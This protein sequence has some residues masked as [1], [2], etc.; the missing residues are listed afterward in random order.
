MKRFL[1]FCIVV[2]FA[3]CKEELPVQRPNVILIMADDLGWGDTGFNG[4]SV[5]QTPNLDK[6]AG[7]GMVFNRFYSASA[8]CSPTRASC[9]IGRNPYRTNVITANSGY[10][11]KEEVT[12]AEVLKSHGYHTGHFGKWHLG[13]LTTKIKDA[14]RGRPGNAEEFSIPTQHG[15]EV[16]F[17]TESKVPT[18]DPMVK[19]KVFQTEKG[20]GLR[21]G[22]EAIDDGDS[23]EAY[24]THYWNG[25]EMMVQEDLTGDDSKIIIDKA[26]D[27][28]KESSATEDP[29]FSVIWLH[30]PH[31]PVVADEK[32]RNMYKT[33]DLQEQLYY[34]TITALDEQIGRLWET[35]GELG[36]QQNTMIWFCSDNGPERG[37]PG[38]SGIYR[39]RKR[40][41]YE[42][43]VRVPAFCVWENGVQPSQI[44][45]VPAVTS[46]YFPTILDM[47][48][49]DHQLNRPMDGVSLKMVMSSEQSERGA[50]IGFLFNN[51]MSWVSDQYK[52]ISTDEGNTFELY[53]LIHDPEEKDNIAAGNEELVEQ[54]RK[55]LLKWKK[56]VENSQQGGDYL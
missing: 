19:P 28:I 21:Y 55:D 18:F 35:L 3:C 37:T 54:M 48:S 1:L 10:L 41:L 2:G 27:F 20:E 46:D 50:S 22:W 56:S 40:S 49:I 14:N 11:K 29:F 43:G 36:E 39:E 4:N 26:M 7:K 12:L 32:H 23:S 53:D 17:S 24:G 42:G 45:S 25:K 51:K 52:L 8:V 16:F 33:H 9:L 34:G 30:T 38:S 31:L 5:I 44:S 6:L 47:L 13:T 15:F